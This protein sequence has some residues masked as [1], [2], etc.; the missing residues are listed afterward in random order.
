MKNIEVLAKEQAT[1][2]TQTIKENREECMIDEEEKIA[3]ARHEACHVMVAVALGY[4]SSASISER[5]L[6]CIKDP[7]MY[8]RL[9]ADDNKDIG[10]AGGETIFYHKLSDHSAPNTEEEITIRIAPLAYRY[11]SGAFDKPQDN[12][13]LIQY[14][15]DFIV[16]QEFLRKFKPKIRDKIYNRCLKSA[17]GILKNNPYGIEHITED[18]VNGKTDVYWMIDEHTMTQMERP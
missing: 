1:S 18:L 16:I 12:D 6:D 9:G 15:S 3:S 17:Y 2:D 13:E 7:D 11:I 10:T 5:K 4:P 8:R 14:G